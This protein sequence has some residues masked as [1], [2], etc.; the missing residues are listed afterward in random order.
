MCQQCFWSTAVYETHRQGY[1]VHTHH[2][3]VQPCPPQCLTRLAGRRIQIELF[4]AHAADPAEQY[5]LTKRWDG[6]RGRG[7]LPLNGVRTRVFYDLRV[8]QLF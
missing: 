6:L 2:P 5:R 1:D 8:R 3:L 4:D 7:T